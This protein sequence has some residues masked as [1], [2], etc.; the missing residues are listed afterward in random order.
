MPEQNSKPPP[1]KDPKKLKDALKALPKINAP[2]YFESD[3]QR[4]LHG[5][6]QDVE[7]KSWL[8][9][10]LPGYALSILGILALAAVGYYV[11]FIPGVQEQPA[12]LST[13]E[14]ENKA[15][16]AV[17]QSPPV[18]KEEVR[19]LDRRPSGQMTGGPAPPG[20]EVL[21]RRLP[22]EPTDTS[23]GESLTAD[24]KGAVRLDAPK[25]S[26]T[27]SRTLRVV[28]FVPETLNRVDTAR[29]HRDSLRAKRDSLKATSDSAM[30]PP[31]K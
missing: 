23:T 6:K 20:E 27:A 14:P 29:I 12:A 9:K 22:P 10:P 11:V 17:T 8:V 16:A 31:H 2:W 25:D 21:H 18:P 1:Q 4:R 5:L 26:T 30:I 15:G 13:V 7:R 19:P 24:A 3:L 28:P